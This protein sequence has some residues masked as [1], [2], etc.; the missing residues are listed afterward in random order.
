MWC[1]PCVQ[2]VACSAPNLMSMLLPK[3][4]VKPIWALDLLMSGV[5]ATAHMPP[6]QLAHNLWCTCQLLQ[7]AYF[8]T[9]LQ[10]IAEY[11]QDRS[12][13]AWPFVG[14]KN[15]VVQAIACSK[16]AYAALEPTS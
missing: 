11:V 16:C 9:S 10:F 15:R 4:F 8:L 1:L 13:Q 14:F 5:H 7:L 3:P 12:R 6:S 2:E